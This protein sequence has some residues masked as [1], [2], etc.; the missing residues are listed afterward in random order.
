MSQSSS[1]LDEVRRNIDEID[2]AIHDLIMQRSA[3][4]AEIAAAK[5]G[6][7]PVLRPGREA[8][9]VRRILGRHA[10]EFPKSVLVRIWREII[11]AFAAMQ[12]PLAAAVYLTERQVGLDRL[13]RDHFGALTPISRFD[14]KRGVLR[15]IADRRATVGLLP[16][17]VG[18]EDEPWWSYLASGRKGTPR[19][20][21]RLPFVLWAGETGEGPAALVVSLAPQE[22]SGEDHSF[23]IAEARQ[24]LS[25][26]ALLKVLAEAGFKG[27]DV[28]SH[29][30]EDGGQLHLIEVEGF[31]AEGDKRLEKLPKLED[32]IAQCWS[33]GSF[34][35]PLAIGRS[36]FEARRRGA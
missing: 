27:L 24:P 25:R 15:A 3:L 19:I 2:S 14:S 6:D 17:P 36:P 26:G 22:E 7:S 35:V 23:L 28:Q 8:R 33:V 31:V 29:R 34:A 4:V 1:R 30:S 5:D 32:S 18:G 12:G 20:I 11:S 21:A 9:I 10:G 16:L 13:A